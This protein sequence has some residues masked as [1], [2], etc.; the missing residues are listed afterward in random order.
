M[1]NY[2]LGGKDHYPAD[3]EA[4]ERVLAAAPDIRAGARA[5]RAFLQRAVR[6]LAAEAGIRQFL[7]IGTGLPTAG[8]VHE[9]AHNAAPESRVVYVDNDPVVLAHAR[10]LLHGVKG[11]TV[12]KHDLREAGGILEDPELRR[13]IDVSQPTAVLLFAILHFI[14]D[15]EQPRAIIDRLLAPLPSG[16]YLVLSHGTADN[17]Q[18]VH[19][20]AK[21]YDKATS[22]GFARSRDQVEAFLTG[23]DLVEPGLVWVPQWRPDPGTELTDD[24]GRS[25]FYGAVARKP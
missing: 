12:L 3:R 25:V 10:D 1:Y 11:T 22:R 20:A 24:P 17:S 15:D 21:V 4:A 8:N 13:L 6:F 16:S 9:V 18:H 23:L 5:N 7:D 14:S 2:Y 19:T